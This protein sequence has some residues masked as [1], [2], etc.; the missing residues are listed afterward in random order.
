M[1]EDAWLLCTDPEA[2]LD[3][4]EGRSGSRK[5]RLFACACCRR[6]W[7]LLTDERSR[8]AVETA[9]RYAD[10]AASEEEREA[11]EQDARDAADELSHRSIDEGTGPD[12]PASS[13]A[14]AAM[15]TL[16]RHFT[17]FDPEGSAPFFA[18]ANAVLALPSPSPSRSSAERAAQSRLLRDIFGPLPFRP[19]AL[20]PAWLTPGVIELASMIYE[21]RAFERLP[22]LAEVLERA[23]CTD[24]EMVEHCRRSGEHTLGCWVVDLLLTRP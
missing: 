24:R 4:L 5:L 21:E 23:G 16:D 10:G 19:V 6:I 22:E 2:M 12:S 1:T 11:A 13:A 14:A 20:N 9:E 3:S 7:P 15:N 17:A 18:A 8:K